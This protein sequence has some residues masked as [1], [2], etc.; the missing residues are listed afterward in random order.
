MTGFK[1]KAS[2]AASLELVTHPESDQEYVHFEAWMDDG[3]KL[4]APKAAPFDPRAAGFSAVNAWW[5]SEAALLSYW[6]DGKARFAERAGLRAEFL[7]R[8]DARADTHCYVATAEDRSFII[9]AFR[10]TQPER[11]ANVWSDV[12]F[13]RTQWREGEQVHEGFKHALDVVWD[14]LAAALRSVAGASVW[15]TGHSLG[16]ALATLAADRFA[17]PAGVYTFGSPRVGDPAFVSGFN[18]RHQDRS[19]RYVN[20]H[21][22]VA[23]VPPSIL[24]FGH[25][26]SERRIEEKGTLSPSP[27][28]S[29]LPAGVIDHTP[30]RYSTFVW[31]ALV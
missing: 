25:V 2:P 9:V 29:L 10:G 20:D 28:A 4:P 23:T 15:F 12:D 17:E 30:R 7:Q 22:L 14:D 27:G 13:P 3:S 6:N 5:L 21:D 26:D 16:G 1:A 18:R 31:N 24:G 11:G 19:F 8:S